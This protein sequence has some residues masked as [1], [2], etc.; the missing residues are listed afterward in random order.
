[1]QRLKRFFRAHRLAIRWRI[2]AE[3]ARWTNPDAYRFFANLMT[4]GY[5]P[6]GLI[7]VVPDHRLI[8]VGVPKAASSTIKKSLSRLA[9]GNAEELQAVH[10]R[11]QSGLLSPSKVGVERFYQLATAPDTLRF[12]FVRN[13]Y[14]R[15]V[16][17][18]A[19]KFQ[20]RPLVGGDPFV[21]V[22]LAYRKATDRSL[23][24]G[25]DAVLPFPVFIEMASATCLMRID[26]HWSLQDDLISMPG[27]T[28]DLIGK[29]ETFDEDYQRVLEHVGK[30]K[31][32]ASSKTTMNVSKRSQC[33]DYFDDALAKRVH[34]AFEKDFD[35]FGYSSALPE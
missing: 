16:S 21:N 5:H 29:A 25:R 30:A 2:K 14:E 34:R 3:P 4:H 7:D 6:D 26:P 18:W 27:I 31:S 20:G 12:S 10:R 22:Y 8:Y 15:L 13:P 17:C 23:P 19:D 35:R 24:H 9:N 28:L 1:M 33:R 32:I 11:R